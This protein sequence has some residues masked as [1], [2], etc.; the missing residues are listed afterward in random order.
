MSQFYLQTYFNYYHPKT[1]NPVRTVSGTTLMLSHHMPNQI[2]PQFSAV[3]LTHIMTAFLPVSFHHT[4][5]ALTA[6]PSVTFHAKDNLTL[7][8]RHPPISQSPPCTINEPPLLTTSLP[9][10]CLPLYQGISLPTPLT[11][12]PQCHFTTLSSIPTQQ[13]HIPL[14]CYSSETV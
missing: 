12:Q 3:I 10:T 5:N 2:F 6:P 14:Q 7:F 9:Q 11:H 8:P 13:T 4:Y 1:P